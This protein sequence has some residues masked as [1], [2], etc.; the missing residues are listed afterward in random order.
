M[1]ANRPHLLPF[2]TECIL[3][4]AALIG[5]ALAPGVALGEED[6]DHVPGEVL[7][8]TAFEFVKFNVDGRATWENHTYIDRQKTLHI[9]G[10][11]RDAEHTITLEP[12]TGQHE[13]TVLVIDPAKYKRTRVRR[14]GQRILTFQQV[15]RP[16][17]KKI[18]KPADPPEP[19]GDSAPKKPRAKGKK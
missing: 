15:F 4:T 6:D 12:R 5:L 16:K 3:V 9:F 14:D 2:R 7:I 18:A 19:A 13:A 17:F 8:K 10:L 1:K 11:S